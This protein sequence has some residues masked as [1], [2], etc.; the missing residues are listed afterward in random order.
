MVASD[1]CSSRLVADYVLVMIGSLLVWL[2]LMFPPC[3]QL[4]TRSSNCCPL[5]LR[6]SCVCAMLCSGRVDMPVAVHDAFLFV[7]R[8]TET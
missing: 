6:G 2:V 5:Y 1:D 7:F 8:T 4:L 3:H